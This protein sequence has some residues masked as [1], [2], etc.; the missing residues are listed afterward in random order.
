MLKAVRNNPGQEK[1]EQ[2]K[3]SKNRQK[4]VPKDSGAIEG[5]ATAFGM[6]LGV[7][8]AFSRIQNLVL[9]R[10]VRVFSRKVERMPSIL[11]GRG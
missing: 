9:E 1:Q 11:C 7:I 10:V 8:G 5:R 3:R 2:E 4:D 6:S